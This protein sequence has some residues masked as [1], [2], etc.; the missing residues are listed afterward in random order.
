M[1]VQQA[2]DYEK[3]VWQ[4][5][6]DEMKQMIPIYHEKGNQYFRAKDYSNALL[7]YSKSL[8][9]CEKLLLR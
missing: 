8:E 9:I 4:M 1:D 7:S 5:S 2:E 6:H 3:E